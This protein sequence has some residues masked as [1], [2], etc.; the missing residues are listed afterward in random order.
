MR[1]RAR[2]STRA[3]VGDDVRPH[4]RSYI[5]TIKIIAA[6][7]NFLTRGDFSLDPGLGGNRAPS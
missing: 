1:W 6:G 2:A 3:L 7:T 4:R 5:G